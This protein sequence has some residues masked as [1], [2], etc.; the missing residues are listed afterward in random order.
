MSAPAPV[1]LLDMELLA[2]ERLSHMTWDYYAGAAEDELTLESNRAAWGEL[3]LRYRVLTGVGDRDL[4]TTV[5]GQRVGWPVL[6]A[7][8]AFHGLACDE[9]ELATARATA[10]SDTAMV[11]S[12]LSNTGVEDVIAAAGDAPVLFQL[13]VYRDRGRTEE[14]VDR[15]VE[16]GAQA[17]VLTVDAPVWGR[18]EADQRNRFS[19]PDGLGIANLGGDA[20]G[21]LPHDVDGSGLAAYV[22]SFFDPDLGWKDVEWLRSLTDLPILVKGL[23]RGDDAAHAVSA[24]AS[25]VVVSNHGGRQLDGAIATARALPDVVDAVGDRA[26]VLVDGG[27]RRGTDVVR[28]LALG[29]RAVMLGR[30][31]LWGL[32]VDGQ[33]GVEDVL[34][35]LRTE[36]DISVALCGARTP[37]GLGPDLIA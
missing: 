18:R 14:L 11:L 4:S 9:A 2:R 32:A 22:M 17:L 27:I 3:E 16:A 7:P 33:Q 24:G 8:T 6:V 37:A 13:Y 25:G 36:L 1:N 28:A 29:A 30:P 10:A 35:M 26:E 5:C 23:V 21:D 31:V 20:T 34:S 15:V 19:L 12:T